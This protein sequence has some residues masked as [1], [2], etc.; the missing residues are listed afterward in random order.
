MK[1]EQFNRRTFLQ[2]LGASAALA[3]FPA[4]LKA[5]P[6]VPRVVVVGGG[7]GGATVAK[8]LKHW[9]GGGVHVTLVDKAPA[10]VS[11][12]LS[13]LVLTNARNLA[14]LTFD[15]DTLVNTYGV[16]FVQAEAVGIN[17]AGN[18]LELGTGASLPFD[19]LA[20]AP[21]VGFDDVPGLE[22][23]KVPH[24]WIAGPQTTLLRNQLAAFP[25]RGSFVI[26]VPPAPY[27]CPPGPYERACLLA[28]YLRLRR[29]RPKVIVL[30]ANPFPVA[31]RHTFE[32]AFSTTYAGIIEY[33]PNVTLDSVDSDRRIAYVTEGG[34]GTSYDADVLNVIPP[35]K[36]G[37]LAFAAGVVPAGGRFAPVNPLSYASIVPN[38]HVLGDS[39]NQGVKSGHIAN[40]ESKICAD[41]LLRFFAGEAPD[42]EPVTNSACYSTISTRTASWLT[43]VFAY[44]GTAVP[45]AMQAVGASLGESDKP[46]SDN[47]Q[48]MFD[49]AAGLFADTFH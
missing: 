47:F 15:F 26:T 41:A 37:P 20:L 31:E 2:F 24:A 33:H 27:R 16:E 23:D 49:W 13:N 17:D 18:R 21:G 4:S 40:S 28:D 44:N 32:T 29:L 30:D 19:R 45:P 35:N 46:S 39:Q 42:P 36:A 48:D 25:R 14:S 8:Y 12:I 10:H 22:F 3:A 5:Q 11:C 7:F 1:M 38:V 6:G 43:A 9:G 34:I